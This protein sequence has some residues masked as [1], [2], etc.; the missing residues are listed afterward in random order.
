MG[1]IYVMGLLQYCPKCIKLNLKKFTYLNLN[2]IK[3]SL[4]LALPYMVAESRCKRENG[5][6]EVTQL[7]AERTSESYQFLVRWPL[8]CPPWEEAKFGGC[9]LC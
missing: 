9:S 5:P 8:S 4:W 3:C 2:N 7:R 6:W 1:L